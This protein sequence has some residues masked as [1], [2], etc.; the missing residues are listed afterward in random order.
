MQKIALSIAVCLASCATSAA[1]ADS[2]DL[3][4]ATVVIRHGELPAA[5]KIAPVILT[6]EITKRTG[7]K[8]PVVDKWPA[9]ADV[10]IAL[11]VKSAAPEWKDQIPS[12]SSSVL[13]KPESFAID[14]IRAQGG[15][16]NMVVI[17][18]SDP[19]GVMFGV[20]K[21]LRSLDWKAGSISLDAE[22]SSHLAPDRAIRGHQIG[23]RAR[24]NSWDAWT[25]EQFDQY[26]RDM[27][28]FGANAVENIPFQDEDKTPLMK[29]SR[30]ELN[31]KF[32]DLCDKYDL[33]HWVWVPVEFTLPDATKGAAFL[34]QQEE[35]YKSCK[36]LD[37][38]FIPGGDPGSNSAK[39]L[40]PYAAEMAK[41]MRKYHP[42]AA[43]WISLQG[44]RG[45]EVD[46]FYAYLEANKPDWLGG[47]VMGPSSPPMAATRKRLP[48]QYKLRWYP[49]ITHVVRCQYPVP[50]L[51]P[52]W[53]VT[54]GREPVN[55]RPVDYAAIYHNDYRYTDGFISYSDGIHDDFN[56]NLWTQLAWEPDCPVRDIAADYARYFF[57]P[58]FAEAGADAIL[59]LETN[60]RGSLIENA[61]VDGTLIQWQQLEQQLS[62]S[63][64]NWRFDMHLFRA[65]YDGYTRHRQIYENELESLALDK[66]GEADKIGVAAALDEARDI[67]NRTTTEP[68]KKEWL[69]R[70]EALAE[71][72][73]QTISYQTS[74]PKYGASGSERGC[75][76]DFV[77]YPLNNRWWLEDQ[78]ERIA[79]MSDK[80]AQIKQIDVIRNWENFGE[81]GYYDV[82]GHVGRSPHMVKLFNGG[83]AMR[84]YYEMPM[85]TQRWMGEQRRGL[86]FA[87]H[88]Y[89][90]RIPGGLTYSALD[91]KA[92][93]TIKLFSQGVTP[94]LIDEKPAKLI[95]KGE[96]YDKVTE[97]E[98]EVPAEA[99]QD[100]K[101]VVDWSRLDQRRLNWRQHHYVT[102]IWVIRRPAAAK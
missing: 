19:R 100:G 57:R 11:S 1:A 67:L 28:V 30:E 82:I 15:R 60:L 89:H 33:E 24:A 25:I 83:D 44:F 31:A 69:G 71:H 70:V 87:W 8:W 86:R 53:G 21:L 54:I 88:T 72:L 42:R 73:F 92:T 63:S 35:F 14:V 95:R 97:Q 91:P 101:I 98:F 12:M 36:R 56:K 32:A 10:I 94:L 66:L 26:F 27:V 9:K 65:Y 7:V 5:E 47:A 61:S 6:E 45:A 34:K 85:P 2:I 81:G 50:W 16:P 80:S 52:A 49:D 17:T 59:A 64:T 22:F 20:G 74:V 90:N 39:D 4:H 29:Y 48:S 102:D 79:G 99:V 41:V 77:N 46:D 43:I 93:Y 68:R 18:G 78:F 13:S 23:Y 76:M 55:P 51:D 40:L 75:M 38:V 84:H 37:A 58:D 62:G 96:T 3:T